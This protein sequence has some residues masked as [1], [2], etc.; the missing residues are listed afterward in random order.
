MNTI[1][2]LL[3][4]ILLYPLFACADTVTSGHGTTVTAERAPEVVVEPTPIPEPTPE[5]APEPMPEP[6][7]LPEPS[8]GWHTIVSQTFDSYPVDTK[9]ND[10]PGFNR[11]YR[12]TVQH[13]DTGKALKVINREGVKQGHGFGVRMDELSSLPAEGLTVVVEFD[14]RFEPGYQFDAASGNLSRTKL[15]RLRYLK[16][17]GEKCGYTDIYF[18]HGSKAG[19]NWYSECLPVK[20]YPGNGKVYFGYGN[21]M[22]AGDWQHI[23]YEITYGT[24]TIANG[25]KSH[26]R[27]WRNGVL[28]GDIRDRLTLRDASDR[29]GQFL[30]INYWNGGA[31]QTQTL[32]VDNFKIEY[33]LP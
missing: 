15:L 2:A 13:T 21:E 12:A 4:L 16:H 9:I 23:R 11:G 22:T 6:T 26:I 3:L 32:W 20:D 33:R 5:P 1:K 14:I 19:Y 29:V 25:G 31:P 18:D 24:A 10:I 28:A 8:P 7:P 30:F 27:L 17:G